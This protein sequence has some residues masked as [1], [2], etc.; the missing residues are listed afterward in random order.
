MISSGVV[1]IWYIRQWYRLWPEQQLFCRLPCPLAPGRNILALVQSINST[2]FGM[3]ALK[4]CIDSALI[5]AFLGSMFPRSY[6]TWGYFSVNISM[7]Y[8][9]IFDIWALNRPKVSSISH[10]KT[11][12]AGRCRNRCVAIRERQL[13]LIR[14]VGPCQSIM[15]HSQQIS[16]FL[17]LSLVGT[18]DLIDRW[19]WRM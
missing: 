2:Q 4:Y 15:S 16:S 19:S 18:A 14:F 3:G 6:S 8:Q 1:I 12:V 13:Y 5:W 11:A 9:N 10:Q 7:L 17:P